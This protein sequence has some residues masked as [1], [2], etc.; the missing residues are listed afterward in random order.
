M[1]V[2]VTPEAPQATRTVD[3]LYREHGAEVYRYAYGILGNRADAEDL[4]QSTF[5][6]VLRAIERGEQPRQPSHWL[7][8]IAHNLA[9]QRFRQAQARP[10]EVAL[11]D[12]IASLHP[13]ND[14]DAPTVDELMRAL[15]RIPETQ[16]TALVMREFE[17]RRYTDIAGVLGI[18]TGALETLIFRARRSVADELQNVVT[19]ARAEEY[20]EGRLAGSLTRKERA[21]LDDHLRECGSCARLQPPE[22]RPASRTRGR[23]LEGLLW[24]PLTLPHALV[25]A[26]RNLLAP[27]ASHGSATAAGAAGGGLA[28][29][30]V[31]VKVAAV[32]V[33]S[34]LVGGIGYE[35]V[36]HIRSQPT[37]HRQPARRSQTTDHTRQ[38]TTGTSSSPAAASRGNQHRSGGATNPPA[39]AKTGSVG[40]TPTAPVTPASNGATVDVGLGHTRVT[41]PRASAHSPA[42]G[43]PKKIDKPSDK[44]P[45]GQTKKAAD[46][47]PAPTT[48]APPDSSAGKSGDA[49][50]RGKS[51]SGA[52]NSSGNANAK[53]K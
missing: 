15:A 51:D 23:A 24:F 45:P 33:S 38:A 27:A 44:A 35:G 19:C 53:A 50:G 16:R 41:T 22:R 7:I 18:S 14:G 39:V 40:K 20:L 12:D 13:T 9:R 28:S 1:G 37:S 49:S 47:V 2:T 42:Q 4:T 11:A 29:T 17:G 8:T 43:T 48:P 25:R 46:T 26:A 21:R 10:T 52:S 30:G 36:Q 3:E 32:V 34:S 6:N 31:A 5:V